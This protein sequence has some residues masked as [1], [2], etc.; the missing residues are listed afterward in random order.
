M[1][2]DFIKVLRKCFSKNSTLVDF[3]H[4]FSKHGKKRLTHTIHLFYF[5]FQHLT[6]GKHGDTSNE[7]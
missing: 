2:W 6:I 4:R 5:Y 1:S 7:L 3:V